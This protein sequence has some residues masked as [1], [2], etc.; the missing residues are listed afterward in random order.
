MKKLLAILLAT[1]ATSTAAA[2]LILPPG[3][4]LTE[5][6]REVAYKTCDRYNE[7]ASLVL[8]G[9][10]VGVPLD[11][12]MD[13]QEVVTVLVIIQEAYELPLFTGETDQMG[14]AEA[15]GAKWEEKCLA[16]YVA[17]INQ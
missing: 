2:D 12:A 11:V 7:T 15:F 6:Q 13:G 3:M 16:N 8:Q 9:R 5:A 4:V 10:Y 17:F 14:Q 1:L